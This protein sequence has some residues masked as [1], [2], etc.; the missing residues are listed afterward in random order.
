LNCIICGSDKHQ[1]AE[2]FE[3]YKVEECTNCAF[4][5]V[6]PIPSPADLDRLYN[7]KEYF[8]SHMNYDFDRIS[9][10]EID[11]NVNNLLALHRNNLTGVTINSTKKFLEIG[12]GGG[13]AMKAFEKMGYQVNGLETSIPAS[14]FIRQRLKLEV[15]NQSFEDFESREKYDLILLNH[16]LEHFLDPV[17]AIVKLKGLLAEGG[18]LYIRVPD[19]D[20]YDRKVWQKKWPAYAHYHISNF[21]EKSLKILASKNGMRV[22]K[23]VKYVSEKAPSAVKWAARIPVLGSYFIQQ[24]NGR[25]ISVIMKKT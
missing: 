1:T 14:E 21:S 3:S 8:T 9:D 5:I 12:P 17:A 7:S 10:A 6:D 13:F 2:T 18:V 4:G 25:S 15:I 20:S 23:T 22:E 11:K 16:V 24:Y 19:H